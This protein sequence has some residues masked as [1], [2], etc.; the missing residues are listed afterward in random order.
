MLSVKEDWMLGCLTWQAFN[1]ALYTYLHFLCIMIP[2]TI[3]L[4][5]Y[6]TV[7][8]I[9]VVLV[10]WCPRLVPKRL[11]MALISAALTLKCIWIR[12][13]YHK[14]SVYPENSFSA[15]WVAANASCPSVKTTSWFFCCF[16]IL[17]KVFFRGPF[18]CIFLQSF[19]SW[20]IYLDVV[21]TNW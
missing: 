7:V 6:C 1:W 2:Y 5:L 16:V 18:I 8:S 21:W 12:P 4:Q 17:C 9:I 14:F 15:V 20:A 10:C 11:E 19:L 13:V 3:D